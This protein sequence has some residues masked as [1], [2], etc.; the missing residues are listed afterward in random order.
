M[1]NP[2]IT[3]GSLSSLVFL[4]LVLQLSLVQGEV[5]LQ[6]GLLTV[7]VEQLPLEE[8]LGELTRQADI[9]V[10]VLEHT[11]VGRV[12]ISTQFWNVPVEEG[13][14]RLLRGWNYGLGRDPATGRIATVYL[15]SPRTVDSSRHPFPHSAMDSASIQKMFDSDANKESPSKGFPYG[16]QA[17]V[18]HHDFDE[19]DDEEEEDENDEDD[20]E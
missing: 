9:Q 1:K 16:V 2:T 12:N 15:V 8:V 19:N 10:I 11:T 17:N 3:R 13:L 14:D 4:V 6:E 7:S 20:E 5:Q 18:E